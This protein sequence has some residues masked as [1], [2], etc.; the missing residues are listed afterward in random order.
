MEEYNTTGGAPQGDIVPVNT[1]SP[2]PVSELGT[3]SAPGVIPSI[4]ERLGGRGGSESAAAKS[5]APK[6][7]EPLAFD[8][9]KLTPDQL[10]QLKAMLNST[11]DRVARRQVNP[12]ITLRQMH[13]ENQDKIVVDYKNAYLAL[14]DDPENNRKVERHI[15]PVKFYGD[16]GFTPVMYKDFMDSPRVRCEAV[17]M[18][19]EPDSHVEGEVYSKERGTMIEMEVRTIRHSFDVRVPGIDKIIRIE[20]RVANA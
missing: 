3:A 18:Y 2:K 8:I 14:V 12:I 7:A 5:N 13:R 16:E 4:A 1:A 15:I 19:S 20:G 6:A 10:Q 9:S 11:P 17:K